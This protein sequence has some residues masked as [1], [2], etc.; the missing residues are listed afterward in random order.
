MPP[1]RT[2]PGSAI[3]RLFADGTAHSPDGLGDRRP[4]NGTMRRSAT[5]RG[6][7]RSKRQPFAEARQR[8]VPWDWIDIGLD[9]QTLRIE[10]LEGV[11]NRLHHIEIDEDDERIQVTVFV[12]LDPDLRGGAYVAV[13]FTAWAMAETNRPVASRRISDGSEE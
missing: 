5:T 11:V 3:S 13:G 10:F 2:Q 6:R 1:D 8:P 9:D 12:G 7:G 4:R